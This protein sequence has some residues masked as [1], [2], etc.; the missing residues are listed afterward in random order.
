MKIFKTAIYFLLILGL[1]LPSFAFAQEGKIPQT[2]EEAKI[3]GMQILTGL[4]NAIKK[5]WQ[6][7]ALPVWLKMWNWL[8]PK[9]EPWWQKFLGLL[10]KEVPSKEQ[11]GQE[12]QKE[13]QEMQKDLW[14]RFKELI[15]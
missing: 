5:V 7:E 13:K 1:I 15:K 11:V 10:G 3:L 9:I 8:R 2:L 14:E 6:E 4:P 12:F